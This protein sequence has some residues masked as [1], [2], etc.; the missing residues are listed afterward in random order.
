[1]LNAPQNRNLGKTPGL[2][3]QVSD[4]VAIK[5]L[6]SGVRKQDERQQVYVLL[7]CWWISSEAQ[8][9]DAWF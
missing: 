7:F 4:D 2:L 3:V 1:M 6:E 8:A 5:K 9:G